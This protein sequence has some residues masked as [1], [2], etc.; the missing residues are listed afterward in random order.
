MQGKIVWLLLIWGLPLMA[1]AN[2]AGF[3]PRDSNDGSNAPYYDKSEE[4]QARAHFQDKDYAGAIPFFKKAVQYD[5]KNAADQYYL[6]RCQAQLGHWREAAF[7]Y[8][9]SNQLKASAIVAAAE[10]RAFEKLSDGDKKWYQ[11]QLKRW[12]KPQ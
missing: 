4:E 5:P 11:N 2:K 8:H 10:K 3:F 9:V 6:G 7:S 1:Q 12:K